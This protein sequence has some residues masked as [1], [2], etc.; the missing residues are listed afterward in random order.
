M[1]SVQGEEGRGLRRVFVEPFTNDTSEAKLETIFRKAF[2]DQFVRIAGYRLVEN[3]RRA[4]VILSGHIVGFSAAP[5]SY[6]EDKLAA[7]ERL[8]VTVEIIFQSG[9]SQQVLWSDRKFSGSE[10]YLLKGTDPLLVR[11]LRSQA[12]EKIASDI[13]ERAYQRMVSGF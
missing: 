11:E 6:R 9:D 7:E 13:A 8:T 2:I 4:D 10:V 5:L 1:D 12:L 3:R